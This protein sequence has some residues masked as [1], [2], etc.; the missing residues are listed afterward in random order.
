[1]SVA[2]WQSRTAEV[3]GTS[4]AAPSATE[5]EWAGA[6]LARATGRL[7]RDVASFT[8]SLSA[9]KRLDAGLEHAYTLRLLPDRSASRVNSDGR[10]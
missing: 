10:G 6:C 7:H 2:L 9:W 5:N 1:M 3:A 4:A 8:T